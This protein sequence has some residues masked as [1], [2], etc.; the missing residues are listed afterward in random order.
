MVSN[1]RQKAMQGLSCPTSLM[2]TIKKHNHGRDQDRHCQF[3]RKNDWS[4]NDQQ[5]KSCHGWLRKLIFCW[6]FFSLMFSWEKQPM[7]NKSPGKKIQRLPSKTY[8]LLNFFKSVVLPR[9]HPRKNN[10]TNKFSSV[11]SKTYFLLIFFSSG[12]LPMK[13]TF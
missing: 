8:F 12:L 4:K 11:T 6:F 7:K 9:I 10:S 13:I 1:H 5:K 2:W 3:S